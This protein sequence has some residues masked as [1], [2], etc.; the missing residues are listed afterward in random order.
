MTT[1]QCDTRLGRVCQGDILSNVNYVES[2]Q[3]TNGQIEVSMIT[4][5][6]AVVVSQEC[7]LQWD[8]EKRPVKFDLISALMIPIYNY[9]HV[10]DGS[11]LKHLG[12]TMG[13]FSPN[14]KKTDNKMLKENKN[15]RYHYIEFPEQIDIVPSVADFKQYFTVSINALIQ[16]K[17][18]DYVC[19]LATPYKERLVQRFSNYLSRIGLPSPNED[20]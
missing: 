12:T 7:D 14:A 8:Y 3:E 11:Y 13:T 5:P 4:F 10:L 1:V 18:H 2:V 19:T 6:Y 15:P 20:S 9:E 17:E 16:L